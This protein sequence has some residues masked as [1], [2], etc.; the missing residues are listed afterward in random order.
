MA[1]V[2]TFSTLV[3]PQQL[4]TSNSNHSPNNSYS[5]QFE[6]VLKSLI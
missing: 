1:K 4:T 5:N 6:K 2:S 3:N